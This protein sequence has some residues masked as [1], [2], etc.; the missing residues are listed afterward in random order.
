MTITQ[1]LEAT[2]QL[3]IREAKERRHEYLTLEHLL[4]ALCSDPMASQVL[5]G[6][7]VTL[8]RLVADL[9]AFLR[10]KVERL[11]V[12][13]E[14][15]EAPDP[16]Q[17]AA[18]WRVFQRAAMHMHGA[19]KDTIDAGS[20]LVS[21]FRE[22]ESHA[23]FLLTK[24]GVTRLSLLRF[25]SHGGGKEGEALLTPH[26]NGEDKGL[27]GPE[28]AGEGSGEDSEEAGPRQDGDPLETFTVNLSRK[29]ARGQVDPLIG[30]E[31]ELSRMIQVLCR[32]RKNNPLLVGDPGVGKTAI[33]LG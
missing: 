19:G 13:V 26:R 17:T 25:V 27:P 29:A 1:E 9:E 20:V 16:K 7:G 6:C 23:V 32:R 15:D 18:F 12:I 10:D 3:A 22:E 8:P 5:G 11:P 24:H 21:M 28:G 2:I 4:F 33:A 14:D 30:R 31:A